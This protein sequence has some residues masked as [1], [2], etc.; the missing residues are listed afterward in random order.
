MDF[1]RALSG[2][3]PEDS[4]L[5]PGGVLK[6]AYSDVCRYSSFLFHIEFS[7][8]PDHAC[9]LHTHAF[10]ELVIVRHGRGRHLIGNSRYPL[11]AGDVFVVR[12]GDVH[13][14]ENM[15]GLDLINII[16]NPDEFLAP[17]RD[18]HHIPGFHV[19]FH[20]EPLYRQAHS[21]SSRLRIGADAMRQLNDLVEPMEREYVR[22]S[23]GFECIIHAYFTLIAAL[24]ARIYTDQQS[25]SAQELLRISRVQ[26]Y[27]QSHYDEQ[28][29]LDQLAEMASMSKNTLLR[30]FHRCYATSPMKYL[31]QLRLSQACRLLAEARLSVTEI[32]HAVGFND[33][34]H[35]TRAFR[36]TFDKSPTDYRKTFSFTS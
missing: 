27:L 18:L 25:A 9:E 29:D 24:L 13:G 7:V 32:A 2:R 26:S 20:L 33:H 31:N 8:F 34:S 10:A 19:L 14:Y 17:N 5:R 4:D 15:E 30:A 6:L 28:I 1:T 23:P 35:F 16:F 12:P 22:G 36:Q 11:E 21:F 3:I